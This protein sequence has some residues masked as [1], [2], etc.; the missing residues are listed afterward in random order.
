MC[1]VEGELTNVL[2]FVRLIQQLR[3]KQM[4]VRGEEIEPIDLSQVSSSTS[5]T[6]NNNTN[7]SN[8]HNDYNNE[9][10]QLT[11][12]SPVIDATQLI[13]EHRKLPFEFFETEDMSV[14]GDVCS[15]YGLKE[16][17]GTIMKKTV[18]SYK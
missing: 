13:N 17:F 1:I 7:N 5:N 2:E 4:V 6:I 10:N 15:N 11:K 9:S 12:H 3:W 8:N 14:V 18:N 16:L